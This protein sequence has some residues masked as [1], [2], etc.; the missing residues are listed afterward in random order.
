MDRLDAAT[1]LCLQHTS[2]LFH[3]FHF[4][5]REGAALTDAAAGSGEECAAGS[6]PDHGGVC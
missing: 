1:D 4:H 3:A 2:L 6:A 5:I